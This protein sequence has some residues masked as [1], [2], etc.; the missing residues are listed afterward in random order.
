MTA[1]SV[2]VGIVDDNVEF[3]EMLSEY[4]A[5]HPGW[6]VSWVLTDG[7]DALVRLK[8]SSVDLVILDIVMPYLDGLG[9]SSAA[10]T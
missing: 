1:R 3:A 10:T 4:V 2:R 8:Q 5:S 6:E 9:C 7:E